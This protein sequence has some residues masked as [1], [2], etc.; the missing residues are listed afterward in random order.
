MF[1]SVPKSKELLFFHFLFVNFFAG[2]YDELARILD[3][4]LTV[5]ATSARASVQPASPPPVAVRDTAPV[6]LQTMFAQSSAAL[7]ASLGALPPP[8]PGTD[9]PTAKDQES[10]PTWSSSHTFLRLRMSVG[11][12]VLELARERSSWIAPSSL[13]LDSDESIAATSQTP[14]LLRLTV[15]HLSAAVRQKRRPRVR[16]DSFSGASLTSKPTT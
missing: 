15:G 3:R 7:R 9:A 5:R 6:P 8:P 11:S 10:Q 14:L 4:V 2:R 1:V 13:H 12:V 16:S